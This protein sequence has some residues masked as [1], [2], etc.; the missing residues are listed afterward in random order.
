MFVGTLKNN[1]QLSVILLLVLASALWL[2]SFLFQLNQPV[3]FDHS[4]H[5][6]Y[7]LIID[8][9]LSYLNR[10][11]ITFLII[12]L[13]A[14]LVNYICITQEII[15]K[16]NYLPAL[17][18][19]LMAFSATNK[20]SIEPILISNIFILPSIYFLINSYR[21]DQALSDFFK[22][23][24]LLSIASF[25]YINYVVV[26]P[27]CYVALFILRPFNWR[28][29][30]LLTLGLLMPLYIFDGINYLVGNKLFTV[31]VLTIE[32]I[33]HFHQPVISEYYV[34][35][36]LVTAILFVFALFFY[37]KNGF[38]GKVK[39]QKSKFILLWMFLCCFTIPFLEQTTEMV[40]LPCIVPISII[41]GDYLAQI[42]QLK[43][44]NT[45]LLL[46]IGGFTVIYLYQL[47]V[48]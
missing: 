8:I 37:V 15:T 20:T 36:L 23:G 9:N 33:T 47:G 18:Y 3:L 5:V 32:K 24:L 10:Q 26:F 25:F 31:F 40:F 11:I 19:L 41:L 29:W 7:K 38:G 35:F 13:G 6:L 2:I 17:I 12:I 22:T 44:A 16:T 39:T 34:V 14:F 43:I 48:V 27:L 21:Q 46:F 42:K 30:V 28:E 1:T 4:E 45:L